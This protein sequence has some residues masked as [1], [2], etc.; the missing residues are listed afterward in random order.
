M[1]KLAKPNTLKR[2]FFYQAAQSW[3]KLPTDLKD[4][5][6]SD[7]VFKHNLKYFI[8]ENSSFL[9]NFASYL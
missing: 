3:N 1:L 9:S 2:S 6:I 7:K 4:L 8:N 5:S